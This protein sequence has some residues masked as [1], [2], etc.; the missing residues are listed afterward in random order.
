VSPYYYHVALHRIPKD[1]YFNEKMSHDTIKI[2]IDIFVKEYNKLNK[3]VYII[4]RVLHM[5]RV[6]VEDYK[7]RYRRKF[8]Y[9]RII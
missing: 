7:L 6:C 8:N 3:I 4:A 2:L 5:I 1:D 9:N